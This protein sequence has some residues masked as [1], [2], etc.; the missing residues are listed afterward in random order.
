MSFLCFYTR[1]LKLTRHEG[2]EIRT[3]VAAFQGDWLG[4]GKGSGENVSLGDFSIRVQ[5]R[6]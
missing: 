1:K 2:L 4:G 5:N 6:I 3:G